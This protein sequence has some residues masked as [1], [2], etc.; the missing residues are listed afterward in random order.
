VIH[1]FRFR[2]LNILLDVNSGSVHVVSDI[3]FDILSFFES[4]A[5]VSRATWAAEKP[6]VIAGMAG[7]YPPDE[8]LEAISDIE[9]LIGE[10]MLFADAPSE[11]EFSPEERGAVI[12]AMC[13]HVAHD[14]NMRCAYCFAGTGDYAGPR[15]LLSAQ[16]G[17]QAIDFLIA[18]SGGRQN[19]E[20]DFFG[21]E[22][23]INMDVVRE[24]V[25]YGRAREKETGK[26]IRFTLTTNGLALDEA[27]TEFLNKEMD[28]VILSLD[29]RPEVNDRVRR[30]PA[31][32]GTYER[33]IGK[34]QAFARAR[35]AAGKLYYVRGTYTGYNKDFAE[36]VR[37][38]VD[39]GF[40]N[41]SVEPV[42]TDASEPYAL[43]EADLP[44]LYAQ[45]D[46]LA[47]M[48]LEY[49][50]A[51]RPF[52]FFHFRLDL[53]QGPCLYKRAAGCGAGTEYVAVTAQGDIY[54][55][56]RFASDAD[57]RLGNVADP[58]F[59]N[60]LYDAFN[61][62]H[63]YSKEACRTCWARFYCSGGCHANAYFE[64]G[65]VNEPYAL[66]CALEKKRLECAIGIYAVT[67][68]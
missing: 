35:E 23:L 5:S 6:A 14:C 61:R 15:A 48:F 53:T 67:A 59:D 12:K 38:L 46:R 24:L 50:E 3:V 30:T 27:V 39:A 37:H 9:E 4:D 32:A 55:C 40:A 51:G 66:G 17:K 1:L 41:V 60:R 45:Y 31:G 54:P 13:L 21:G 47:D 10:D 58:A 42:V 44:A 34:L 25:A 43:T 57:F 29:G 28:N 64:N 18:Q 36:D 52:S 16:T 63:I 20:I 33:I 2:D 49:E 26:H 62:A 11:A 22:P 19:L 8:I 65:S 68:E 7:R 56:H